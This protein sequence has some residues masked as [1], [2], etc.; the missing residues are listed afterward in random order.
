MPIQSG[1][2]PPKSIEYSEE[3]ENDENLLPEFG[4]R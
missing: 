3:T 2:I 1:N 4:G